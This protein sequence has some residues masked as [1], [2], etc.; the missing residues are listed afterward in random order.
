V[1]TG[2]R[3]GSGSLGENGSGFLNAYLSLPQGQREGVGQLVRDLAQ[4]V[5]RQHPRG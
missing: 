4:Y 2:R 5:E 3:S 1:I